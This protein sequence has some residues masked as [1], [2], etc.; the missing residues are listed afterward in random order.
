MSISAGFSAVTCLPVSESSSAFPRSD[1]R[2]ADRPAVTVRHALP[3][4]IQAEL[5][6]LTGDA[7]VTGEC[8]LEPTSQT[9]PLD[10]RDNRL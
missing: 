7:D 10:G 8:G 5:R 3:D 1:E 2:Q 4:V 6:V 9:P